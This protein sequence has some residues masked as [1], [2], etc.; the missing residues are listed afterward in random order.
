MS[1]WVVVTGGASGIGLATATRLA[2]ER[3]IL[4][5]DRD[6]AALAAAREEVA[7]AGIR[8]GAAVADVNTPA[9]VAAAL[10]RIPP[11]DHIHGLVNSAAVFEHHPAESMPIAAW[12]RVID[13]NLTGSFIC[14]QAA[15]PRMRPGSVIVN[16]SSI[17]GHAALPDHANYAVSKAGVMM[18][19]R[20]LGVEWARH[21]IRVV[22][23]SPAVVDTPMNRRMDE[24]GRQDPRVVKDRTPLGR[25]A[26]P[27]EI[28]DVIN[29][30]LSGQASYITG[31][32]VAVD[33]GWTAYGAM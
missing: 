6:A 5:L 7:H 28:A 30:L 32:D 23:L 25:Y 4:L 19:S 16:L 1:G 22:S 12:R 21:G 10:D 18:L 2:A 17:N 31:T 29:F 13:V 27:G 24:E 14:C 3:P 8:T 26:E 9:E 11:E 20:C 33:G 15:F